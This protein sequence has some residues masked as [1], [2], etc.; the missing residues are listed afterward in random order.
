[1][2]DACVSTLWYINAQCFVKISYP[3]S[4]FELRSQAT[5]WWSWYYMLPIEIIQLES[6]TDCMYQY[7]INNKQQIFILFL[8][9]HFSLH[10]DDLYVLSNQIPCWSFLVWLFSEYSLLGSCC[11]YEATVLY[12][13]AFLTWTFI[14]LKQGKYNGA[15][16]C[17]RPS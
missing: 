10:L 2:L 12:S 4:K 7:L 15:H 8:D 14:I 3:S 1:M 6:R 13:F 5:P 9:F 16:Q 11:K 17:A